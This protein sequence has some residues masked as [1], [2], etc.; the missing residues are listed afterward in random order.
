[1]RTKLATAALAGALGLTGVAGAAL[2]VPAV[3]YAA[4]GDST[5]LTERVTSL[6]EALAGLVTDG[7]L[8]Q[9]QADTVASTLAE[10]APLHGQGRH[11][12]GPGGMLGHGGPGHGGRGGGLDLSVAAEALGVTEE[13]LRA[14]GEDGKTLAD[15]AAEQGVEQG[16]LVDALVAAAQERLATAVEEGRI[17]QEQADDR[18]EDLEARIPDRLDDVPLPG[19]RGHG[20]RG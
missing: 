20:P 8:T 2:L 14:A 17:T 12:G 4:T 6:K 5:A 16:V 1:M 13:E 11:G 10:A 7:T 19:G 15:V 9:A 18:A 3:S